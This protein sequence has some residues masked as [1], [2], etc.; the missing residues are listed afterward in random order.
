MVLG[1]RN[2]SLAIWLIL[3]PE[4]SSHITRYSR[5]E[6]VSCPF[7]ASP[8]TTMSRSEARICFRPLLTT[9]WSSAISTR[10]DLSTVRPPSHRHPPKELVFGRQRQDD[11]DPGPL[12]PAVSFRPGELD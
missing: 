9:G 1:D 3:R 6:S 2:I 12:P 10:M 5:S 8:T 4:A 7:F 11:G